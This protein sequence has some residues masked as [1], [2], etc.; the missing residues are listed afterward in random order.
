MKMQIL[1]YY[2]YVAQIAKIVYL[3]HVKRSTF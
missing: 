3:D 2:N 1:E